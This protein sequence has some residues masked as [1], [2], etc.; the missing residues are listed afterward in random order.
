[1]CVCGGERRGAGRGGV[2]C[3]WVEPVCLAGLLPHKDAPRLCIHI[4]CMLSLLLDC[5]LTHQSMPHRSCRL[6]ASNC[7]RPG[8]PSTMDSSKLP[9]PAAP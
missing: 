5:G 2:K 9:W 3:G 6:S 1:M 4:H 8:R 7:T